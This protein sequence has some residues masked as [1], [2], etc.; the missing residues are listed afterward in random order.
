[1]DARTHTHTHARTHART[2]THP[3]RHTHTHTH[4]PT[5][6]HTHTHTQ[7]IYFLRDSDDLLFMR[8]RENIAHNTADTGAL[9]ETG[10][11]IIKIKRKNK[12][13]MN[14]LA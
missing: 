6:T 1:M 10:T 7:M 2:H 4:T 9:V 11:Q 3:H 13:K 12:N 8:E 5:H 14:I